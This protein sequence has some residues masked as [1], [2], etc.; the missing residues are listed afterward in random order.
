MA[1]APDYKPK[2][3]EYA[4]LISDDIALL[5]GGAKLGKRKEDK[6]RMAQLKGEL[7]EV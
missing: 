3:Q 5:T 7:R 4:S 2:L 6:P 1:S